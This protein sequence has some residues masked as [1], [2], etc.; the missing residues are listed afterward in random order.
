MIHVAGL[1]ILSM[2]VVV[3]KWPNNLA[4]LYNV[5]YPSS[6]LFGS[7]TPYM[8]FKCLDLSCVTCNEQTC[9][10]VLICAVRIMR[11]VEFK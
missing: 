6:S 4:V 9:I 10:A 5:W 3:F 11:D 1:D 8:A 2:I 7:G